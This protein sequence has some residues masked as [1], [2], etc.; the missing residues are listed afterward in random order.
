MRHGPLEGTGSLRRS[1]TNR[2][3]FTYQRAAGPEPACYSTALEFACCG[4]ASVEI[5]NLVGD[6]V[7]DIP[8]GILDRGLGIGWAACEKHDEPDQLLVSPGVAPVIQPARDGPREGRGKFVLLHGFA[9]VD[10]A[11]GRFLARLP[12]RKIDHKENQLR[13]RLKLLIRREEIPRPRG[14]V[15]HTGSRRR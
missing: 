12:R 5:R 7:H 6:V 9:D 14:A 1:L 10:A 13:L 2:S 3:R 8:G 4:D 15:F 11:F